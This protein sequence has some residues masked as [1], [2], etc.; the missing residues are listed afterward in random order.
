MKNAQY[1]STEEIENLLGDWYFPS[2]MFFSTCRTWNLWEIEISP[3]CSTDRPWNQF[4]LKF[5]EGLEDVNSRRDTYR[6]GLTRFSL[7]HLADR[8]IHPCFKMFII[9]LTRSHSLTL[10]GTNCANKC[11]LIS[12]SFSR[13][14]SKIASPYCIVLI[15]TLSTLK[16]LLGKSQTKYFFAETHHSTNHSKII[17]SFYNFFQTT[18]SFA[19]YNFFQTTNRFAFY[20]F[21]Q[22]TN[23]FAFHNFFQTTNRFAFYNFFQTTNRF[24]FYNFFQ[25]TSSFPP[26]YDILYSTIFSIDLTRGCLYHPTTLHTSHGSRL[27]TTH[28]GSQRLTTHDDSRR[29]TTTHDDSPLTTHDSR[30]LTTTHDDSRRLTTTHD[31][32][33]RLTTHDSRLTTTHENFFFRYELLFSIQSN[34]IFSHLHKNNKAKFHSFISQHAISR[35]SRQH[36]L[37]SQTWLQLW[38]AIHRPKQFLF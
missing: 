29:L 20:N 28:D 3:M 26:F 4:S 13:P 7:L 2:K 8:R 25:T 33:R 30:R 34:L 1:Y 5:C 12:F 21:F 16:S 11:V 32:S 31:D 35:K 14:W 38:H 36:R 17:S 6:V 24:A 15:C 9:H 18:N 27:T 22:T 19:F 23:R 37:Y 10:S